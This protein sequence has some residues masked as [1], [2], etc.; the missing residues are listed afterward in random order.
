LTIA[1]PSCAAAWPILGEGRVTQGLRCYPDHAAAGAWWYVSDRLELAEDAGR[2][3]FSFERF[4][5]AGTTATG[6]SGTFWGKGLLS[7]TVRFESPAAVLALAESELSRFAGRPVALQPLPIERMD[8]EL[9]W[10]PIGSEAEG[11]DLRGGWDEERAGA[12][13]TERAYLVGLGPRDAELLWEAYQ[14]EGVALSLGYSLVGRVLPSRPPPE[15]AEQPEPEPLTLAGGA[16]PIQVKPADCPQCFTS[17]DLDAEIPAGYTFVDVYC[18]D[19]ADGATAP[20]DLGVVITE[21]RAT[22]ID[23]NHPVE[24]VRFTPGS[25]ARAGVHFRFA[26]HLESGYDYRVSRVFQDGRVESGDWQRVARWS[27]ILDVTARRAADARL[28]PRELY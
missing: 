2:P 26:V 10:A 19:F 9:L 4:R 15:R 6:D 11:G 3:R 17:Q 22:A 24:Q 1:T 12:V 7:F 27:G 16:L 20:S 18:H 13:W 28:D 5:Y 23:G 21:V 25:D 8:A 14:D